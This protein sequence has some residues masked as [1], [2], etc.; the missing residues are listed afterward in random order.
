MRYSSLQKKITC[1]KEQIKFLEKL[2]EEIEYDLKDIDVSKK[3]SKKYLDT[4]NKSIEK[5]K[6][7]VLNDVKKSVRVMG[8][9][10]NVINKLDNTN[11]KIIL[12]YKY[13]DMHTYEEIEELTHI[14]RSNLF[15]YHKKALEEL[16]G[17][18]LGKL[19]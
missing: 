19:D 1:G 3:I 10:Y 17:F 18:I 13:I 6:K 11:Y 15:R 9:I 14:S 16:Q 12:I 7:Q 8:E 4:C 5:I 2:I